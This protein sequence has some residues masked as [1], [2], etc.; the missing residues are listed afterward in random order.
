M[1]HKMIVGNHLCPDKTAFK[2]RMD[3]SCRLR[4]LRALCNGPCPG[5]V[6]PRSQETDETKNMITG[7]DQFFQ[8]R[9]CKTKILQKHF[10]LI[11]IQLR[12]L[13]L[14][15]GTDHKNLGSFFPGKFPYLIHLFISDGLIRQFILRHIGR[16]DHRFRRKQI[17]FIKP[18]RFILI[19]Q[20]KVLRQTAILQKRFEPFHQFHLSG[21]LLIVIGTTGS[22]GYPSIQN[23]NIR[24][25]QLQIY[26]LDIPERINAAVH[27]DNVGVLK[28]SH[29]MNNGIHFTDVGKK[30]VPQPLSFGSPFHQPGDIDK[31]NDS[32]NRLL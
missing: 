21:Q 20:F 28:A 16:I 27:M 26:G 25:D 24:E 9:F 2:I 12:N 4:R 31:F 5:L 11:L 8:S 14:D 22:L 18:C 30:L 7:P 3:L 29:N 32:R 23:L 1:L 13:L 17:I 6:G 10:L 19:R 15:L